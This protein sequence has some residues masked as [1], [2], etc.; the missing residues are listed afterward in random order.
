M[1]DDEKIKCYTVREVADI[2]KLSARTVY[3]LIATGQLRAVRV[4]KHIRVPHDA[5]LELLSQQETQSAA[6]M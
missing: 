1:V 2:L 3:Y 5:L 4:G 6:K